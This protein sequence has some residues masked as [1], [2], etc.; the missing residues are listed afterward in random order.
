MELKVWVEG[1]QRVVCGVTEATTCQV[2]DSLSGA[3]GIL[4]N[5]SR[6]ATSQVDLMMMEPLL[7]YTRL[8][9]I[10]IIFAIFSSPTTTAVSDIYE[11][12]R[13]LAGVPILALRRE[14]MLWECFISPIIIISPSQWHLPSSLYHC[15]AFLYY[16][17]CVAYRYSHRSRL[18]IKTERFMKNKKSRRNVSA[19]WKITILIPISTLPLS[20]PGRG[21]CISPCHQ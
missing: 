4:T 17:P 5:R 2:K 9:N 12:M 7:F 16:H 21:V 14:I 11:E 6:S 13:V 20:I 15:N 19:I 3:L 1:I 18:L 8:I 10:A